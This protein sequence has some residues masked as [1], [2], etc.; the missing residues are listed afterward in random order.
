[1]FHQGTTRHSETPCMTSIIAEYYCLL[2]VVAAEWISGI[3]VL[4]V[5]G[6]KVVLGLKVISESHH[7][8]LKPV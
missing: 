8:D 2:I 7:Q 5:S 3:L 4:S 6:F 1:M